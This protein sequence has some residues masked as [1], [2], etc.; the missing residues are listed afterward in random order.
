[1]KKSLSLFATA[2]LLLV[3]FPFFAQGATKTITQTP[4]IAIATGPLSDQSVGMAVRGKI[5]YVIGTVTGV[6][7]TDGFIQALDGTG[8]VQWSLP[9]DNG[10][11]EIATAATFD[12]SGNI[13]IA[14]SAQ[15][16]QT[17]PT[18][19]PSST[20]SP[21]PTPS[22]STSPTPSVSASPQIS[23]TPTPTPTST[24]L[25]PD[26]VTTD[27]AVPMRKDLTSLVLWKVSPAGVLLGTYLSEISASF[28][29]RS[30]AFAN[31]A[32]NV[33]GIISTSSG[34][35]GMLVQ[36]DLS[37]TYSKPIVVGKSDTE[38]NALAKRSDGSLLL[39]GSSSETIAKQGL[40]GT[41]DGILVVVSPTGKISSVVRSSNASST[42]S[43]QSATN[44][45]FL[46]GDANA[47]GKKEAVVT[48]FSSALIPTWTMRFSSASP[49]LTADSSTSHFLAFSSLGAITGLKGWKPSKT[50]VLLVSLDSKGTL[51]GAYGAPQIA[52]PMAIGY[53]RELGIVVL[54]RGQTGVSIFHVLPR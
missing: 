11:N 12:S 18:P 33:V 31:N 21:T 46:G 47:S 24:V 3:A 35:A 43:W 10:S 27:P 20:P 14:G 41:K 15:T 32:I 9:L 6:A 36:S 34:H 52:V 4:M 23:S 51:N 44:S 5:I 7:T 42:R 26:G 19:T 37:G 30:A 28:L 54:G 25:N 29:I 16:P 13:W 22:V 50:S 17:S 53:S 40:K 48:K 39:L 45:Y 49:A 1:V 8:K 38:V 2:T